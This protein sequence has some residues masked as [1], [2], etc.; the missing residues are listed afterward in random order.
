MPTRKP[1]VV[2]ESKPGPEWDMDYTLQENP[3]WKTE[4]QRR[5]ERDIMIKMRLQEGRNVFYRSSGWSLYPQVHCGDGCTY[6]PVTS[7][8]EVQV[9][10]IVFCEVQPGDRFYAHLVLEAEEDWRS[11]KMRYIIG[12]ASGRQNG[13]CHIEH[14]Y[15]RLVKVEK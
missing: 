2:T 14:I 7:E 3:E 1:I 13:W 12:N 5:H 15:G 8:Q 9:N 6:T 4:L 10:D 11:D